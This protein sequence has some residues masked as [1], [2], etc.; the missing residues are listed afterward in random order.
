M[1]YLAKVYV[2][3]LSAFLSIYLSYLAKLGVFLLLFFVCLF[4]L[5]RAA[6]KVYGG[7]QARGQ[8]KAAPQLQQSGIQAKSTKYTTV[9]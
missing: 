1:N 9:H 4:G 8:V 2:L 6:P 7:S 3:F 5:S